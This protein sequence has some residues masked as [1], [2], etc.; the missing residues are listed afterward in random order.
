MMKTLSMF[1]P[2]SLA[3]WLVSTHCVGQDLSAAF[4]S[5]LLRRFTHTEPGASVLIIK[6]GKPLYRKAFGQAN[7]EL[8]VAMKPD[9][10]FAIGSIT[11]QITASAILK[12]AREGRFSLQDPIT[13]FIPDYPTHG[14]TITVEHLLTHSSGIKNITEIPR[15][16][17]E[18]QK[19]TFTPQELVDYFKQEPVDFVPGEQFH[20]SNSGYI[21]LGYIIELVTGK[22]FGK[23]IQET[24]LGPL[25]LTRTYYSDHSR[26]LSDRASGYQQDKGYFENADYLSVTQPYAAGSVLSTVDDLYRWYEAVMSGRVL[27]WE[28]RQKA[29]TPYQLKNGTLAP[30]GYGWRL[31]NI[32]GSPSVSHGGLVNGYAGF[33]LYLPNEQVFVALLT[34]CD[35]NT[36][37]PELT[38]QLAALAIGRPYAWNRHPLN[39]HQLAAYQGVYESLAGSQQIVSYEADRLVIYRP[40]NRK[41][42]LIPLGNNHFAVGNSLIRIE[43]SRGKGGQEAFLVEHSTGLPTKWVRTSKLH[44]SR[45]VLKV[46][47]PVLQAYVGS[48]QFKPGLTFEVSRQGDKLYGRLSGAGQRQQEIIPYEA[49]KFFAREVDATLEF[50]LDQQGI[51]TGLVLRQNGTKTAQ[52]LN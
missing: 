18:V 2:L 33:T 4:D 48:Y 10:L 9:Q 45:P 14:H 11:K 23:Y 6:E 17:P 47:V 32:Q 20:Y 37:L 3:C 8:K 42:E 38:A 5:L 15:W 30:Y 35:C 25:G 27:H 41:E 50:S 40:K 16:T 36:D 13:K 49:H 12:L 44:L 52:K 19:K 26:L 34:S 31:G 1:F 39:G 46:T 43:F 29:H 22:P 21:L 7:L 28:D 24:F 51:V